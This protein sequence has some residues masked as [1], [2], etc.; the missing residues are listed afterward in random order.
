[1]DGPFILHCRSPGPDMLHARKCHACG[2]SQAGVL[3]AV[4]GTD[5]QQPVLQSEYLDLRWNA[6]TIQG[7]QSGW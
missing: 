7:D 4:G 1:M 6:I 5:E 3:Y 2:V